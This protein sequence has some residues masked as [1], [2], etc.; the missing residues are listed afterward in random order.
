LGD[1]GHGLSEGQKRKIALARAF[2]GKPAI[3]FLDELGNGLD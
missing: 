1:F 2:Y 3:L